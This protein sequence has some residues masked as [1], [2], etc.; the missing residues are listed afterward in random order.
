MTT[1]PDAA[2]TR[3]E[4][5]EIEADS[6]PENQTER[7]VDDELEE[8]LAD[9]RKDEPKPEPRQETSTTVESRLK[10]IEERNRA[11]EERETQAEIKRRLDDTVSEIMKAAP[12]L[13]K[14]GNKAVRGFLVD[15]LYSDANLF[16]A[17][18][19][20]PGAVKKIARSLAKR[21]ADAVPETKDRDDTDAVLAEVRGVSTRAPQPPDDTEFARNASSQEFWEKHG[22]VM[23]GY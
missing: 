5:P 2:N 22:G 14:I 10:R 9:Y 7:S 13:N 4:V 18:S 23:R 11:Q 3:E 17:F 21:Y 8:I 20:G 16:T 12:D 19:S 15:D 6:T 1:D